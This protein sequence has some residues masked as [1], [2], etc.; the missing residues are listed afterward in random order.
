MDIGTAEGATTERQ[1]ATRAG[2]EVEAVRVEE[3]ARAATEVHLAIT[4]A[5][6]MSS[7][8]LLTEASQY[9]RLTLYTR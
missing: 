1:R 8:N 6:S 4:N 7:T 5:S 2:D 3:A 9:G